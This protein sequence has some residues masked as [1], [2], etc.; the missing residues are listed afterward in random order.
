MHELVREFEEPL[1]DASGAMYMAQVHGTQRRD[2]KWEGHLSFT[3]MTTGDTLKT[4]RESL[5]SDMNDLQYWALGLTPQYVRAAL[6]RVLAQNWE[7]AVASGPAIALHLSAPDERVSEIMG[8]YSL[9]HGMQRVIPGGSLLIYRDT[10]YTGSDRRDYAFDLHSGEDVQAS[11]AWLSE[12][13]A[14]TRVSIDGE[15]I[16]L[17]EAEIAAAISRGAARQRVQSSSVPQ[18]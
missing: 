3:P 7:N 4:S 6:E 13:M 1:T 11:A 16:G 12:L 2:G 8:T 5:Q 9:K 18:P 15:A 17:N 14:G 10:G